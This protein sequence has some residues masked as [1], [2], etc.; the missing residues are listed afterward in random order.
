M[1]NEQVTERERQE[2]ENAVYLVEGWQNLGVIEG[3]QTYQGRC[4][5]WAIIVR[6]SGDEIPSESCKVEAEAYRTVVVGPGP[7]PHVHFSP[8]FA[9]NTLRRA[10]KDES[11]RALRAIYPLPKRKRGFKTVK[12]RGRR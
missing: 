4:G 1:Q 2:A 8:S 6:V 9:R 12:A 7:Y 3:K 11:E 10:M 5:P